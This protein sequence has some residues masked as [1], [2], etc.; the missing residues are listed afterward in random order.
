MSPMIKQYVGDNG[1]YYSALS[2]LVFLGILALSPYNKISSRGIPQPITMSTKSRSNRPRC[3]PDS[4][5]AASATVPTYEKRA[6]SRPS[7]LQLHLKSLYEDLPPPIYIGNIRRI[8]DI[9]YIPIS[10]LLSDHGAALRTSL[11]SNGMSV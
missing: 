4:E 5:S 9:D 7:P 8:T 2:A 6:E 10:Y 11:L 3:K 1:F